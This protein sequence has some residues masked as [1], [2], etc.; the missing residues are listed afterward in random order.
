MGSAATIIHTTATIK[1]TINAIVNILIMA[2]AHVSRQLGS[3][4]LDNVEVGYKSFYE[5]S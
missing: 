3:T 2:I 5:L 1:S 4:T